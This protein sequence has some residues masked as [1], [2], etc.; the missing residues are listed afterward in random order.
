MKIMYFVALAIVLQIASTQLENEGEIIIPENQS[1]DLSGVL[2]QLFL[3]DVPRCPASSCKEIADY[4]LWSPRSGL[5]WLTDG[6]TLFQVYCVNSISP[7][8][9]RGWLRVGYISSSQ[10]CPT[11][12]E[13]ITGGRRKL[14]RR[15][16]PHGCSSITLFTHGLSYN[17]VCGRVYG[18]QRGRTGGFVRSNCPN[19][20]IDQPYLEGVSLTIGSPRQH[21][22][23]LA[24]AHLAALCPCSD[25]PLDY[26]L[27]SF[28]GQDYFCDVEGSGTFISSDR[29]WDGRGCPL[30]AEQC[31]DKGSWFCKDFSKI[32]TDNIEFR[33]CGDELRTRE[34]VYIEFA[35]IYVQ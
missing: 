22:W 15:T 33:V 9:S 30:D 23:S 35:E 18:Y 19:C 32:T 11:G 16:V 5:H 4:K 3:G 34:D 12:L 31:C 1:N 27:P 2:C 28:I 25:N 29:L 13:Q 7:S 17:K 10:G 21:I 6:R 24:A 20:T 14:C 8:Q 26:D